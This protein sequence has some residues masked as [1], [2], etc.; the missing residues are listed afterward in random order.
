MQK[1]NITTTHYIGK[2]SK[3]KISVTT[4]FILPHSEKMLGCRLVRLELKVNMD[5]Y[6]DFLRWRKRKG[7]ICCVIGKYNI[8]TSDA[9]TF[10]IHILNKP[11]S[12]INREIKLRSNLLLFYE[13]AV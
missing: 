4:G 10:G 3:K 6:S 11:I 9:A 5:R 8:A 13:S 1:S 2:L 7:T 12:Y